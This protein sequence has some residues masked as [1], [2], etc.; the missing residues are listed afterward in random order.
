MTDAV[1]VGAEPCRV[2][3]CPRLADPHPLGCSARRANWRF[4]LIGLLCLLLLVLPFYHCY[5]SLSPRL[6]PLRAAGVAAGLVAGGLIAFWRLGNHL[7][8]VPPGEGLRAMTMLEVS[9][10]GQDRCWRQ[11]TGALLAGV[12]PSRR[13]PRSM[14]RTHRPCR[15]AVSRVGVLGIV[16]TGM[17]SGYG[18][19]SLPFSYISLFIRPVDR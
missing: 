19:V 17:L 3:G 6:A 7:P 1:A 2:P 10:E 18:S 15:Q 14:P 4:D 8:G 5:V 13:R 16:L 9:R 12:R 11:L